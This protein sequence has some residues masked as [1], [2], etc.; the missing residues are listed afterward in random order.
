[1]IAEFVVCLLSAAGIATGLFV[2]HSGWAAIL[3]YHA[4][5]LCALISGVP[6]KVEWRSIFK[7]YRTGPALG[8]VLLSFLTGLGF[9]LLIHHSGAS[10]AYLLKKL[11]RAGFSLSTFWLFVLYASVINPVLE[12]LFWRGDP[13]RARGWVSDL[14]YAL[15]HTPILYSVGRS[16]PHHVGLCLLG[17]TLAGAVWRWVAHKQNGLATSI[18]GHAA[19]DLALLAAVIFSLG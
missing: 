16:A 6:R 5:L 9:F 13:S 4:V 19:S 7:G 17:L 8:L 15:L 10:E 12:E 14:F 11:S 1:M 3:L 18:I 2:F